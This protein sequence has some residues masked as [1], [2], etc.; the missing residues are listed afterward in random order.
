MDAGP[1]GTA[2]PGA[3]ISVILGSKAALPEVPATLPG[4]DRERWLC[5]EATAVQVLRR[6][7]CLCN[8]CH[9]ATH[10]G[11]T[12]ELFAQRSRT[13]WRLDL[14][15][16][17]AAGVRVTWPPAPRQRLASPARP[18]RPPATAKPISLDQGTSIPAPLNGA[19][20]LVRV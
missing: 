1:P 18:W 15:I 7:I 4:E 6:L 3:D 16:L 12:F 13:R 8:D 5:Q 2:C 9:T 20:A 10:V 14:R 17:D 19:P 11:A